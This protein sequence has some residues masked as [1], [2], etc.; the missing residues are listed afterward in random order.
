M[1][2]WY[3]QMEYYDW[4]AWLKY[5][6]HGVNH[7]ENEIECDPQ[8]RARCNIAPNGSAQITRSHVKKGIT[9]ARPERFYDRG[10]IG[11]VK[12]EEVQ[13][14]EINAGEKRKE[15]VEQKEVFF[16]P[17]RRRRRRRLPSF[18]NVE[19]ERI[20]QVVVNGHLES[21]AFFINRGE[22]SEVV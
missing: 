22:T 16:V 12:I 7:S 20:E 1:P 11:E 10:E 15:R 3:G 2:G 18:K 13:E 21:G 6:V 19:E 17:R 4:G 9:G 14:P 5:I 8:T